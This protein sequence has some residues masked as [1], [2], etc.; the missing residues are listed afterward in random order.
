M[1]KS[2][3]LLLSILLVLSLVACNSDRKSKDGVEKGEE[4]VLK[5]ADENISAPAEEEDSSE[6]ENDYLY[7]DVPNE[8]EIHINPALER[9]PDADEAYTPKAYFVNHSEYELIYFELGLRNKQKGQFGIKI[10]KPAPLGPGETS[11]VSRIMATVP[12]EEDDLYPSF[13]F[14]RIMVDGE[15]REFEYDYYS[16]EYI[17]W[18]AENMKGNYRNSY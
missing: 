15:E 13:F 7:I 6:S 17:D 12:I 4:T 16:E 11:K 3:T 14:Y 1:K 9:N 10:S 5:D 2:L 8:I 18:K